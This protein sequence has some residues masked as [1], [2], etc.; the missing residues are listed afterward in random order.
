MNRCLYYYKAVLFFFF[1]WST[2]R[3]LGIPFLLYTTIK[4]TFYY[5]LEWHYADLKKTLQLEA[6]HR[7]SLIVAYL[8]FATTSNASKS[9]FIVLLVRE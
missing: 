9:I 4:W 3:S 5:Y 6:A 2:T 1:C 8:L 7:Q